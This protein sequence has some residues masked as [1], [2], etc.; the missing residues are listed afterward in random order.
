MTE[1]T[2][3]PTLRNRKSAPRSSTS[4]ASEGAD[5]ARRAN[6]R[7]RQSQSEDRARQHCIKDLRPLVWLHGKIASP[8]PNAGGHGRCRPPNRIKSPSATA[9]KPLIHLRSLQI[10]FRHLPRRHRPQIAIAPRRPLPSCSSDCGFLPWR[11]SDDGP[12]ACAH[13]RDRAGVRN[14]SKHANKAPSPKNKSQNKDE[15]SLIRW[16]VQEI[17]RVTIGLD[18]S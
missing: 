6:H 7:P 2:R 8:Q 14:P 1:R 17:Q 10:V 15:N 12:R 4:C 9:P 16:S 11:L 18:Q 3:R 5:G 13:C